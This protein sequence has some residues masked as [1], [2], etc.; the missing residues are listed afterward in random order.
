[1]GLH[2]ACPMGCAF[3]EEAKAWNGFGG[4]LKYKSVGVIGVCWE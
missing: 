1:M 3:G 4:A 2:D